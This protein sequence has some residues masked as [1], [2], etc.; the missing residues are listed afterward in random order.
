MASVWI[1]CSEGEW[2]VVCSNLV[3]AYSL[4]SSLCQKPPSFYTVCNQLSNQSIHVL[5]MYP[6]QVRMY[7]GIYSPPIKEEWFPN[8]ITRMTLSEVVSHPL[9]LYKKKQIEEIRMFDMN[10]KAYVKKHANPF[11]I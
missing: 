4:G 6:T 2:Y 3:E 8:G 5:S 10:M 1:S 9:Y 7:Q 11:L